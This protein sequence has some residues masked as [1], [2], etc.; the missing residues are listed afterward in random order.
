MLR[1]TILSFIY[2]S[3]IIIIIIVVILLWLYFKILTK[4]IDLYAKNSAR[5]DKRGFESIS[6]QQHSLETVSKI[7]RMRRKAIQLVGN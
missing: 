4:T 7:K 2:G 3:V 6:I 5:N 1:W